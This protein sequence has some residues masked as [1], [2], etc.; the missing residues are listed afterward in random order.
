MLDHLV[1]GERKG[2]LRMIAS[3]SMKDILAQYM[4]VTEICLAAM[5]FFGST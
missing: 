3:D 2:M 1:K 5:T 4:R